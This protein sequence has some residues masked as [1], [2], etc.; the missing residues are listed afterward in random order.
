MPSLSEISYSRDVSIAAV[1]DY[2]NFI[3]K[4]Y[5]EESEVIYL[6]EGGW[7]HITSENLKGCGK[8]DEVIAMLRQLP[9]SC[10]VYS[11][12]KA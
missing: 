7:P 5:V 2:Y 4:M 10:V 11:K 1:R 3:V 12:C 8:T 9:R 6:P